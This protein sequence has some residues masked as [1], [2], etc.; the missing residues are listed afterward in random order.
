MSLKSNLQDVLSGLVRSTDIYESRGTDQD[1]NETPA[2]VAVDVFHA[3]TE[4]DWQ[5]GQ[6]KMQRVIARIESSSSVAGDGYQEH[7]GTIT[8][9]NE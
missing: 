9:L 1:S 6:E 3:Y 2:F 8:F 4:E 5:A 7:D